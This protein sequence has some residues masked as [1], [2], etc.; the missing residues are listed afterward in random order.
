MHLGEW[1]RCYYLYSVVCQQIWCNVLPLFFPRYTGVKKTQHYKLFIS[2]PIVLFWR[3]KKKTTTTKQD[4]VKLCAVSNS[5]YTG[6]FFIEEGGWFVFFLWI[7][8]K[9]KKGS[10]TRYVDFF[11]LLLKLIFDRI[12]I[13]PPKKIGVYRTSVVRSVRLSVRSSHFFVSPTHF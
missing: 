12:L 5:I 7:G 6:I 1:Y 8:I 13:P 9:G 10:F 2:D 11:I 4:V 3:T